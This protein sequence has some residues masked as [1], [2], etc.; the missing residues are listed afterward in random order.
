MHSFLKFNEYELN[1]YYMSGTVWCN[2]ATQ[3]NITQSLLAADC[4]C[5]P[6]SYVEI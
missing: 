4:V 5:L 3:M 6:N 2:G 1:V